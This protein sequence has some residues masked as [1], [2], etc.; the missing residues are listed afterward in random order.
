MTDEALTTSIQDDPMFRALS[1]KVSHQ[2]ELILKIALGLEANTKATDEINGKVD[3]LG[4][5]TGELVKAFKS[6]KGAFEVLEWAG[7]VSKVLLP[8]FLAFGSMAYAGEWV[9]S[10]V[11]LMFGAH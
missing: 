11:K 2:S 9:W 7:K 10:K 1:E 3:R 5:D 4:D 8:V 6:A